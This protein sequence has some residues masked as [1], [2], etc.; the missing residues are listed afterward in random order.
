MEDVILEEEVIIACVNF[1]VTEERGF[2]VNWLHTSEE[3]IT[4]DAYD[5]EIH[6]LC[7]GETWQRKHLGLFLIKLVNLA[8]MTKLQWE[9][10]LNQDYTIM[11][12]A[13]TS[14][15]QNGPK[16]YLSLGFVEGDIVDVDS[17]LE[18]ETYPGFSDILE[19]A[20]TSTN[21]YIHFIFSEELTVFKNVTGTFGSNKSYAV[22][23]KNAGKFPELAEDTMVGR[24]VTSFHFPF[25]FKRTWFMILSMDLDFFFLPFT[26][27]TEMYDY[28]Q[29]N[30]VFNDNH[31]VV[32]S[33]RDA[34]LLKDKTGWLED[35][36][37]DFLIRW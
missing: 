3:K 13:H 4:H 23:Y 25:A 16:F 27:E 11:L 26:V 36:T 10:K 1:A 9:G 32:V 22:Q 8:V 24:D 17:V 19:R 6:I 14:G 2:F 35:T 30:S 5:S 33:Q 21:D 34:A 7:G 12:Q 31:K 28:I 20:R 15:K 18:R 37:I 29:A